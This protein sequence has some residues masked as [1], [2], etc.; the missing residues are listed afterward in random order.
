MPSNRINSPNS[1]S[2]VST[3]ERI[4]SSVASLFN[5]IARNS[6]P[7][8]VSGMDSAARMTRTIRIIGAITSSTV[9]MSEGRQS[10]SFNALICPFTDPTTFMSVPPIST[11]HNMEFC[12]AF[13]APLKAVSASDAVSPELGKTFS[14]LPR[15]ISKL[16]GGQF[17]AEFTLSV[18]LRHLP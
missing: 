11:P 16:K 3:A 6:F 5:M 14:H 10:Y 7:L 4:S 2:A 1:F 8:P 12:A 18:T 17:I 13:T 9:F 15:T